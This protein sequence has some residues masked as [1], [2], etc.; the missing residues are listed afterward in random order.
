M[1]ARNLFLAAKQADER[2]QRDAQVIWDLHRRVSALEKLDLDQRLTTV[3][4]LVVKQGETV[5]SRLRWLV[6]G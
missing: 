4:D 6:R 3:E 2:L 5:W 1:A